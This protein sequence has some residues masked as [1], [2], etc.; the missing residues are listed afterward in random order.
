[1]RS[2]IGSPKPRKYFATRSVASGVAGSRNGEALI[3]LATL[4]LI[5]L[6][7]DVSEGGEQTGER[8][9]TVGELG[10]RTGMSAKATREFEG[11][12]LIY[13][14]GRS[15]ANYRLFDECLRPSDRYV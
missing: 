3:A 7:S 14:A 1:M 2:R 13:S 4:E 15:E 9:M 10:R 12:G 8:L 11:L 6:L 5:S